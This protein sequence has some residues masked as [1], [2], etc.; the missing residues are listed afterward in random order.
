MRPATCDLVRDRLPD[1]L[2]GRMPPDE[3]R[4]VLGHL[5]DCAAC[6]AEAEL[7]RMLRRNA[8]RA[9]G[10]LEAQVKAALAARPRRWSFGV[11][12]PALIAATVGAALLGGAALLRQQ[13]RAGAPAAPPVSVAAPDSRTISAADGHALMQPLP[14]ATDESLYSSTTSLD[15]LSVEELQ[16]LLK[17]MQS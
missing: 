3:A 5:D 11:T 8:V 15:D 13:Q 7:V 9:P 4:V 12:R 16:T 17:E 6:A 10:G 14:G 2:A 1:A